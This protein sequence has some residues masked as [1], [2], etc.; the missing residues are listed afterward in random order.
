MTDCA[1]AAATR[2][3]AET[4]FVADERCTGAAALSAAVSVPCSTGVLIVR[5]AGA[6]VGVGVGAGEVASGTA[7]WAAGGGVADAA[8]S[9]AGGAT[10]TGAAWPAAASVACASAAV[11][12][13]A[14]TAAIAVIPERSGGVWLI[15]GNLTVAQ[16]IRSTP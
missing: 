5:I 12:D 15:I 4:L 11:E 7:S 6:A 2:V 13:K 16:R 1:G 14:I 9:G 8:G 10:T 3:E